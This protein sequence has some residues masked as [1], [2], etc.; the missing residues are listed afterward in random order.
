MLDVFEGRLF[1]GNAFEARDLKRL[2]DRRIWAVVDVAAEESPAA[3]GRDLIYLRVPLIDG[4]ENES[5]QVA[6]VLQCLVILI[7]QRTPTLVACS[8]GASR[9]PCLAAAALNVVYGRSTGEWLELF[10]AG[11]PLDVCPAFLASVEET[12]AQLK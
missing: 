10:R 9:S 7:R 3:L 1:V 8:V 11:K 4:A 5:G 2:Y 6:L 12:A